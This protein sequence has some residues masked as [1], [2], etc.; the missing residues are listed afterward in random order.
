MTNVLVCIKR[1][2]DIAG[3]VVLDEAGTALDGRYSGYTISDHE[4]AA[5]ELAIAVAEAGSGSV[6]VLTVGD[7]DAVEQLRYALSFGAHDAIRIAAAS[8][9][10]RPEDIAAAIADV[11]SAHD[12]GY[13]LVLLGND[14]ADTG[15]FQ[16]GIRLA[17]A[18]D[19]PVVSRV[20]Q[21][22]V[23]DGV[24]HLRARSAEGTERYEVALPAVACVLEGGVSPRYPSMRGRMRAK[25]APIDTVTPARRLQG[26][27]ALG[28]RVPPVEGGEVTILGEGPGAVPAIVDVL[29]RTG[30]VS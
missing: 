15:D 28:L 5:V 10:H 2:V 6:T 29:R 26:T 27:G 18:L 3:H 14:A 4:L 17:Y 25:K 7:E 22:E 1:S 16:V 24:A 12:P 9:E 19:W 11:V 20:Q 13:D 8:T 21:V 30:V 23:R